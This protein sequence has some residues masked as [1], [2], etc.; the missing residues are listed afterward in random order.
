MENSH[1]LPVGYRF[2]PTDNEIILYYLFNK[3]SGVSIPSNPIKDFDLY[4]DNDQTMMKVFQD[5]SQEKNFYF[6]TKLKK[7]HGKGMRIQRITGLGTWKETQKEKNIS[8]ENQIIGTKRGFKFVPK[9][10]FELNSRWLMDEFRLHS[11]LLNQTNQFDEYVVC[12]IKNEKELR[13][14]SHFYEEDNKV[15]Q[16]Q[17]ASLQ[18][19]S[20]TFN[21]K[22][23]QH[24]SELMDTIS[25]NLWTTQ[26][27][28]EP[29]QLDMISDNDWITEEELEKLLLD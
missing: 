29:L 14:K 17:E 1:N 20:G 13:S 8:W 4:D 10:G 18:S 15:T 12:H 16:E 2:R 26:E 9:K 27:V 6:F 3:A 19:D 22:L 24:G 23:H 5:T 28:L 11:S 25:D 21:L 7:K